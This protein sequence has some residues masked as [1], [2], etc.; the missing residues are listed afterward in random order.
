MIIP[1]L[2]NALEPIVHRQRWLW[3]LRG[4]SLSFAVLAVLALFLRASSIPFPTTLLILAGLVLVALVSRMAE[5]W[6]P[7]YPSIARAIE[8]RH[9]ELHAAL[10]TAVEQRPDPRTGKLHFL[11]QRVIADAVAHAERE[12][13]I[14]AVPKFKLGAHAVLSAALCGLF[15]FAAVQV[16]RKVRPPQRAS[17]NIATQENAVEI[18][19]GDTAIE[20]GSGFF[21]LAKFR[22]MVPGEA[23]LVIERPNASPERHALV[24]NLDDPVFGGGLPEVDSSFRYHVE[25]SGDSSRTFAVKV[26]EHPRL[27]H[28]DATV[29]YPEYTR[30]P[31]KEIPDTRRISA[32]EG[33][34][35]DVAFQLNKPVKSAELVTR[36]GKKVPLAVDPAKPAAA[37][38]DFAVVASETYELHLVDDEGRTNKVPAQLALDAL[39]NRRPELKFAAPRG[40][41]RVSPIEE[42]TFRAETW[43][44]FGL[45]RYGMT[46]NIAGRGDQQ[47]ELGKASA[48]DERREVNHLVK[49]EELGVKPDELLSW[50]LWAEDIGP[51]GKARTTASDMYFGEVRPFEEIYRRGDDQEAANQ[52]QQQQQGGGRGGQAQKL[53]ELQKQIIS[54]T[55]NLKRA[56]DSAPQSPTEKYKKD[57]PVIRDSQSE[58]LQKATEL[59]EGVEDP[60]SRG[61]ID[62]IT[63]Q[64]KAALD[65]LNAAAKAPATLPDAVAAEQL[66]YNALLKLAAHEYR[67]TRQQRGSA[68]GGGQQ[69]NQ[70]QLDQLE[71]KDEKQRYETKREAQPMQNEQQAEQLAILN[72]LKELAQRQQDI[73]E[74]LKELQTALQEAKTEREKEELARQLKRLREEEQ[75]LL[76]DL[77]E[78]RQKMD[79][80]SQQSQFAD[81]RR[82]L[83]QTRGEAQ[84]AAEA[85]EQRAAS[86]ALASGT[87]AARNLQE[88]RDD[89]RKKTTG[90][91][92]EEMRQMRSDAR[93]LAEQQAEIGEK[94]KGDPASSQRRRTLDASP[95]NEVA[96]KLEKQQG[97]LKQ[98]TE[99]MKRIS[100]QAEAAEPLLS[101]ELYDTLR[102]TTQDGTDRT[103]EMTQQLAQRGYSTEAQKFEEKARQGI[104]ALKTGVERAAE[105]V[106]GNEADA[107]RRARAELDT[108]TNELNREIARARPD[109][110]ATEPGQANRQNAN[111]GARGDGKEEEQRQNRESP[112]DRNQE[113]NG[114]GNPRDENSGENSA[115][116]GAL[117]QNNDRQN[118]RSGERAGQQENREQAGAQPGERRGENGEE[119]SESG[120]RAQ[121]GGQAQTGNQAGE[122]QGAEQRDGRGRQPGGQQGRG[123]QGQTAQRDQSQ[124]NQS[125]AQGSGRGQQGTAQGNGNRGEQAPGES[126]QQGGD[127]TAQ[128][129]EQGNAATGNGNRGNAA[130]DGRLRDRRPRSLTVLAT[131]PRGG[132]RRG[133]TT[134]GDGNELERYGP[135][136]GE[137]F[138]QWSDRL[139]NVEEMIDD[140]ALRTE[141]ARVRELAK[142]MRVEFK[143]HGVMPN[144]D[145]VNTK[146]RAPLAEIRDRVSEELAR[147]EPKDR[148]V[149]I[150]RDPVPTQF[151]ERVRRYYED[152]GRS[153]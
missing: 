142:G 37:L 110:A 85:M 146:I 17:A 62:N 32:V 115:R 124:E 48:A 66:A 151:A 73:N 135:L 79:Q 99:A 77:D 129:G 29:H 33:S 53:A 35:L 69:A 81:E 14:E 58:A 134:G 153:R 36:T 132:P 103:L 21:V 123:G 98:L 8:Q 38:R 89:F 84:K 141:A 119:N 140:P 87:R 108:L 143:R 31:D 54:A 56:E 109:L 82:K 136:T 26:F 60:K 70:Q 105:S 68:G 116:N 92:N 118:A 20:R 144:W 113:A 3:K 150:D 42:V 25:Y 16:A 59:G 72:R 131:A 90:R 78:A 67:V 101:K 112:S 39:P 106:L 97:D 63:A 46:V 114:N 1:L 5:N 133:A 27:E 18:T 45:S 75:Q 107:L 138:A 24:K 126:S 2:E 125:T 65:R 102:K 47:I 94:L 4:W 61:L 76:A 57:H 147:R 40:D 117:A 41:R 22:D 130:A 88:M 34:K 148:L 30:L 74:K 93:Q 145:L 111:G 19:P 52:Q 51:D 43:D 139:R 100:E 10:L 55:W 64:M 9:P 7:D 28:A 95:K 121:S 71:L 104:D 6:Q 152:L 23:T 12:R 96:E 122:P 15:V 11:Q 137:D 44:D 91:F 120:E 13:W 127:E 80:S 86:Q 128:A 83:D 149:P 50:F 49:L